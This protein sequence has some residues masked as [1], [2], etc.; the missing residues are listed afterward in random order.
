MVVIP[1]SGRLYGKYTDRGLESL[2]A[3]LKDC[4]KGLKVDYRILVDRDGWVDIELEGVDM[5]IAARLVSNLLGVRPR[6]RGDL[7]RYTAWVGR[8]EAITS[9]GIV[10][11]M[12]L[13]KAV[14]ASRTVSLQ[15][16][17][18]YEEAVAR[19]GL[20]PNVPVEVAICRMNGG[21]RYVAC[22]SDNFLAKLHGWGVT[23]LNRI[24]ITGVTSSIVRR[25]L[26]KSYMERYVA[27]YERL[28]ILEHHIVCK[29][30]SNP[31]RIAQA[32][33]S[34]LKGVDVYVVKPKPIGYLSLLHT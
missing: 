16:E 5:D 1:T 33:K 28:G 11:D 27:Y 26:K 12:K 29:I 20:Y 32:L 21:D 2:N 23:G 13:I 22:F 31:Y 34:I 4:L 18:S 6:D 30:A 9:E 19:Y 25:H 14:V 24:L 10:I 7:D 15:L 3:T 17:N 8:V